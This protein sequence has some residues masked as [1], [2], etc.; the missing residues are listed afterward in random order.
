MLVDK[1]DFVEF[2]RQWRGLFED[3]CDYE[4]VVNG[5]AAPV[6][7]NK[8]LGWTYVNLSNYHPDTL[9][10]R[11]K[12][13]ASDVLRVLHEHKCKIT[14][15]FRKKPEPLPEGWQRNAAYDSEVV[16]EITYEGF[17]LRMRVEESTH[18]FYD[19]VYT[20]TVDFIC[21]KF[22]YESMFRVYTH[23]HDVN[24]CGVL[25]GFRQAIQRAESEAKRFIGQ[26][27]FWG[28]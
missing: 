22:A 26:F 28:D 23:T 9:S 19:F 11:S 4:L 3:G 21:P 18:P 12:C 13:M 8:T 25:T 20:P 6:A 15:S 24:K 7:Q 17:S 14:L 2:D 27:V 10:L 16:R 1:I 5:E